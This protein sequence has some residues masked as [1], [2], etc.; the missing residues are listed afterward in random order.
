VSVTVANAGHYIQL[1][2]PRVV[3][4]AI[5]DVVEQVRHSGAD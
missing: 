1:D 5:H 3:V 2:Q 4:D